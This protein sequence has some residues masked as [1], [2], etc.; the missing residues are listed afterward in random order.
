MNTKDKQ[1]LLAYLKSQHLIF[2]ASSSQNPWI[3]T[4][5]FAV[6]DN[7]DIYFISES[8][9]LHGK[10]I[11]DN[12][13]V[14]CGIADSKQ[15]V[16]EEKI[17][18]QLAGVASE[19]TDE[20][21]IRYALALWNASN[22]G[23]EKIINFDNLYKINTNVYIIRPTLIKFFN[24]KLYGQ[25]GFRILKNKIEAQ[26]LFKGLIDLESLPDKSLNKYISVGYFKEKNP[27]GNPAYFYVHKVIVKGKTIDN[28][29]RLLSKKLKKGWYAVFWNNNSSY[30]IF[31]NKI[32]K[33]SYNWTADEFKKVTRYATSVGIKNIHFLHIKKS[34]ENW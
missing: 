7:F 1:K 4:L 22:P 33:V 16:N 13:K 24:E 18:V 9:S 11:L 29:T 25:E 32:I 10:N 23:L 14:S 5:Y 6:D 31:K 21:E 30:F 26:F 17:G 2:L 8:K 19:I 27:D 34:M 3:A 28:A 15:K 12:K 20:N